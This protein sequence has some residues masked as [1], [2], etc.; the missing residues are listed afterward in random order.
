M[1]GT[2]GNWLGKMDAERRLR[3]LHDLLGTLHPALL[4][5]LPYRPECRIPNILQ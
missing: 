3:V 1:Q 4:S 2:S 5:A